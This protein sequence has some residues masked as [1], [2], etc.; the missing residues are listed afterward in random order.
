MDLVGAYRKACEV[1]SPQPRGRV[2]RFARYRTQ[3]TAFAQIT[4]LICSRVVRSVM[5]G[6]A[7]VHSTRR[8]GLG[9]FGQAPQRHSSSLASACWDNG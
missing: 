9:R 1:A 8:N 2:Q 7:P 4:E 3:L 6:H 5:S